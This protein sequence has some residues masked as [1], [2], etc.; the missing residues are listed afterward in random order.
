MSRIN[1]VPLSVN[2]AWQGRKWKT[3]EYK[4]FER[5]CLLM[6][7]KI[8]VPE[9]PFRIEY[10]FGFSNK[11]SDLLNPEKLVTD[12]LCKKYGINDRDVFEMSL[13]KEITPKGKEYIEFEITHC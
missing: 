7:P 12:I 4:R 8:K 3:P 1:I 9:P 5:D 13:K 11:L 2:R 6:L 10:R